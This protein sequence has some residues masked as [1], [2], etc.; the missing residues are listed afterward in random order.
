M[1]PIKNMIS[2]TDPVRNDP[3][4]PDGEAALR[5]MLTEPA[6]FSDNFRA[7]ATPLEERRLRRARL[8]G[9]ITLAAAAVTAGVLAATNLG[10]VTSTPGPASTVTGSATRSPATPQTSSD[11]A[12]VPA[13]P[14]PT[15]TPTQASSVQTFVFPD[16]HLSFTYPDGW[17][18]RTEQGP[19]LT[20]E[21][22][23]GSVVAVVADDSGSEVARVLSGMYGDGAA[24][25]VRRTVLDHTP[26]PGITDA[27][28]NPAEF[29]F[30]ADQ[31]LPVSYPGMP[32]P[33]QPADSNALYYF[34]DVRLAQEFLPTQDSS[35]TN[36]I[37][38]PNGVL[39]AY[40]IFDAD[41][42]PVFATPEAAR[43][44]MAGERYAQLKAL[45]LS[46]KYS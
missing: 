35:G 10:P 31:I 34:M 16:G 13:G 37:P 3:S 29:G 8:A 27:S 39:S 30:A 33:T 7:V 19:Y 25:S 5:R 32:E 28:G 4:T 21:A 46:L 15:G 23:A 9:V 6:A 45:L 2:A 38:L 26:V 14:A 41:K 43:E 1:D 24:G 40:V 20:E 44:W 12:S 17:S 36:Q 18:V 22:K 11:P 42:Q